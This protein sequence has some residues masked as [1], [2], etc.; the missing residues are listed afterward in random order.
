MFKIRKL[1]TSVL[2]TAGR[3]L[4]QFPVS[5]DFS[6][7]LILPAALWPWVGNVSISLRN[8]SQES[9]W[10]GGAKNSWCIRLTA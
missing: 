9:Y 5:L 4:V 7:D 2:F 10:G 1:C 8:E 3:L 6:V